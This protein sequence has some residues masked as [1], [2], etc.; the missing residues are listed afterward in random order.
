MQTIK[1]VGPV[2]GERIIAERKK[3]A[4]KSDDDLKARVQGVGD[5]V[6]EN[7]RK[8][9]VKA[10]ATKARARAR[11]PARANAPRAR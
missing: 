8:G 4:F 7:I 11:P 5:V 10:R 2:I 6:A 3:G 1:G 9:V